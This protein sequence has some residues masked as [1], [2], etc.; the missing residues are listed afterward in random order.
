MAFEN[1]IPVANYELGVASPYQGFLAGQKFAGDQAAQQAQTGLTQAQTASIGLNNQQEQ[2]KIDQAAQAQ[3]RQKA[4]IQAIQ[5]L[6]SSP[7]AQQYLQLNQQ[8]PDFS[9]QT[10]DIAAQWGTERTKNETLASVQYLRTLDSDP[11]KAA[12]LAADRAQASGNAGDQMMAQ[13]WKAHADE[14]Q[15]LAGVTDPAQR[16]QMADALRNHTMLQVAAVNPKGFEDILKGLKA[17]GEIAQTNLTGAKIGEEVQTA[18]LKRKLDLLDTQIRQANSETE[19]GKLQV[20]RDKLAFEIQQK[21][22]A[23]QQAAQGAMDTAAQSLSTVASL[24]NAP[25]LSSATGAGHQFNTWY[26]SGESA[27]FRAQLAVLKSQQFATN[28][29]AMKASGATLGG[30]SNAEGDKIQSTVA[31]IDPDVQSPTSLRNQLGIIKATLEKAQQRAIASGKL[32]MTG[33]AFVLD[34]PR[35]GTVTEGTINALMA[36]RPGTTRAQVMQ[37][38]Q[39]T[40]GKLPLLEQPT[41]PGAAPVSGVNASQD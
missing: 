35:F 19:R 4:Y 16:Q 41:V 10:G 40:G 27:D 33:G 6:G 18:Q 22:G 28:I 11:A 5:G 37:Y 34:H 36:R 2:L 29:E 32:P 26:K 9:K 23:T 39:D 1:P 13:F 12:Q 31:N 24:L 17:P 7:T 8:F 25:G 21:Q 20:D 30:L 38:L 3:A 15:R 14:A